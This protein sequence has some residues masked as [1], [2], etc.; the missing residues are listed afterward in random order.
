MRTWAREGRSV[1][2]VEEVVKS[3]TELRP[4]EVVVKVR[5]ISEKKRTNRENIKLVIV[6]LWQRVCSS[7]T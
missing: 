5:L 7:R 1:C 6:L 2:A 3:R 4:T